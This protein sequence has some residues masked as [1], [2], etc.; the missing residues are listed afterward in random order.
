MIPGVD[1]S[2]RDLLRKRLPDGTAVLL[3][4]PDDRQP[5]V[6]L[7]LFGLRDDTGGRSAGWDDVRGADGTLLGRRAPTRRYQ[8]SYVVQ[9]H[10][11]DP[12][13]E[14][15]LLGQALIALTDEDTG[16]DLKLG[17][18][19]PCELGFPPVAS[20]VLTVNALHTPALD[21]ELAK[22]AEAVHLGV[23]NTVRPLPTASNGK[24]Q[25]SRKRIEE[26]S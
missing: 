25:W 21:T 14:H 19:M 18:A 4:A 22:P 17:Q 8:L 16:L 9:A 26:T 10:A 20:F 5:A 23:A 3:A 11:A 12:E 1:Q 2:L 15:E 13:A 24:K 7:T 6:S